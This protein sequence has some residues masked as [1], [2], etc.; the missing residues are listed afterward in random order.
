MGVNKRCNRCNNVN[1]QCNKWPLIGGDRART[2]DLMRAKHTFYLLNYTPFLKRQSYNHL[3]EIL[4]IDAQQLLTEKPHKIKYRT[5]PIHTLLIDIH[6]SITSPG[7]IHTSLINIASDVW[8]L[9]SDVTM[10][11][12]TSLHTLLAM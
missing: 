2:D 12:L 1:K 10:W 5:V 7:N 8:M 9:K 11:K 3:T 6:T 4:N